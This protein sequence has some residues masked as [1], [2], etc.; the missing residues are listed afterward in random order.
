MR[1]LVKEKLEVAKGTLL[2]VFDLQG[3]EVDFRPGQYFWVELPNRGYDDEKGLRRHISVVTSPTERGVLGLCTRMRDTAFKNTLAELEVGDAVDV[4]QPKGDWQ[5]PED[6]RKHYVFVAGGIG[7]TV[8]RSMLRYIAD[9]G[10][11]YQVT[12]VYSNRD[13][14]STPFLDELQG[15]EAEIAGLRLVLTMTDDEGWDGEARRVSREMLTDHL[16]DLSEPTYLVAGPP[17]MVESVVESLADAGL[18][19]DQVLP[20]RFSGY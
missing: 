9:T 20:D 18:P 8:F 2:V 7:I 12:L 1:A 17:A 19:E 4:E 10:E 15:L 13:R 3:E 16:G 14:E 11:P 5:L 6:T